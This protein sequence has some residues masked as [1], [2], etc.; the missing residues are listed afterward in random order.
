MSPRALHTSK[1]V[2]D[3]EKVLLH[4]LSNSRAFS[5]TGDIFSDN[6]FATAIA[7]TFLNN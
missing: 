7:K 1:V 5:D 3:I 2:T 4:S 6:F